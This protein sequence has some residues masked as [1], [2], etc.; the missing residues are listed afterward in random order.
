M[1]CNDLKGG[2]LMQIECAC[3]HKSPPTIR[4]LLFKPISSKTG[5]KSRYQ[6]CSE[7]LAKTSYEKHIRKVLHYKENTSWLVSCQFLRFHR[8][9]FLISRVFINP[10]RKTLRF[11]GRDI[12]GRGWAEMLD[13]LLK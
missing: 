8:P 9:C 13:A 11:S 10:P 4:C 5:G 7:L 3:L 2:E 12:W 1:F 6:C